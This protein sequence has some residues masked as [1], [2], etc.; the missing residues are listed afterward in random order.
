[1]KQRSMVLGVISLLLLALVAWGQ[2]PQGQ[3]RRGGQGTQGG[4]FDP[5]QML[6]QRVDRLAT[7]LNLTDAQK[8]QALSIFRDAAKATMPLQQ[9]MREARQALQ[10]AVKANDTAK[11]DQLS[12]TVGTLTGQ[13]TAINSKAEAQF[14]AALT[15]EQ[16]AKIP[17]TPFGLFG[18]FGFGGPG[19]GAGG[20][21]RGPP[22]QNQ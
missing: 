3:R 8:T 20:E 18:G 16:K 4:S 21:R 1:M 11:I 14:I 17:N 9:Q 7:E 12:T 5:Q 6:Q 13:S 2:D 22:R 19:G 10:D 15:P